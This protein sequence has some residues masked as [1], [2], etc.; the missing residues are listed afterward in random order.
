[1]KCRKLVVVLGVIALVVVLATANSSS[2]GAASS[3]CGACD[4]TFGVDGLALGFAGL[5]YEAIVQPDGKTLLLVGGLDELSVTVERLDVD[6][7]P[8]YGFDLDGIAELRFHQ[9]SLKEFPAALTLAPDLAGDA[10]DFDIVISGWIRL[11]ATSNDSKGKGKKNRNSTTDHMVVARMNSDGSLLYSYASTPLESGFG[12][13]GVLILDADSSQ[14]G[15]AG[16]AVDSQGR[17][18]VSARF[19]FG[20]S[21][22]EGAVFRVDPHGTGRELF[23]KVPVL[24]GSIAVVSS[25]DVVGQIGAGGNKVVRWTAQ[26]VIDTNFV[27]IDVPGISIHM[28]VSR[29][30]G[31][32]FVASVLQSRVASGKGRNKTITDTDTVVVSRYDANGGFLSK[33][34]SYDGG[35]TDRIQDLEI[36]PEGRVVAVVESHDDTG[37]NKTFEGVVRWNT[38]GTMDLFSY[39]FSGPLLTGVSSYSVAFN[40]PDD[41]TDPPEYPMSVMVLGGWTRPSPVQPAAIR[42]FR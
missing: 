19:G 39:A 7:S 13:D 12:T 29:I 16:I 33:F 40:P 20:S 35:A 26:G 17:I 10:G 27:P 30:D 3:L 24:V 41:G 4:P 1:M 21:N 42:M 22:G 37:N 18:L 6:G 2:V 23:Q 5:A 9:D 31:S 14:P 11:A 15:D 8:D 34:G 25:D 36:D 38:D 28:A 32:V